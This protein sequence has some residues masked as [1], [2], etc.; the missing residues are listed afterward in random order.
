MPDAEIGH[1]INLGC[2]RRWVEDWDNVDGGLW[3]KRLWLR[4]IGLIRRIRPLERVLP[5]KLRQ[6]PRDVIVWDL[7]KTPLPF[8]DGTAEVVFS[9]YVLEYLTVEDTQRLLRD[10]RRILRPGGII[11]LC[12]TDIGLGIE[13]YLA[14][15]DLEPSPA[16]LTRT[17]DFHERLNGEHTKLSVRLLH[18]GGHQQLFD[19]PSL[20]WLLQEAGFDDIQVVAKGEGR[21]P[22]LDRL[23]AD[24]APVPMIRMEASVPA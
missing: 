24:F 16:A 9:Q 22:S 17:R 7:R 20:R 6:Y 21:C 15:G 11:R 13:Q 4:A 14:K 19:E 18:A 8:G 1:R 3:A 5:R 2:G 23:E 10:C 12:Q